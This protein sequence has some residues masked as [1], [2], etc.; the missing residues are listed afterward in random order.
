M[1]TRD[2]V[3]GGRLFW[4]Q[5]NPGAGW[6]NTICTVSPGI[7]KGNSDL[8]EAS[9]EAN[10]KLIAAAPELDMKVARLLVLLGEALGAI[11]DDL[12]AAGPD[13]VRQHPSL[14]RRRRIANKI[15]KVLK[16]NLT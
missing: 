16:E 14:R 9:C 10:A 13:E 1:E 12:L 4:I 5:A 6:G 8:N 2:R 15:T 11:E 7:D 3:G